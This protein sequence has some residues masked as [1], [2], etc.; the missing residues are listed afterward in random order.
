MFAQLRHKSLS[1]SPGA[2]RPATR[3]RGAALVE[4]AI[5]LPVLIILVLGVIDLGRV[6]Y[7]YEALVN[8][9]R[10]GARYCAL[11]PGDTPG[12]TDRVRREINYNLGGTWLVAVNVG[13]TTCPSPGPGKPL[14]VTATATFDPLTPLIETIT[15]GSTL[16]ISSTATMV[17]WQ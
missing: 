3:E 16:T 17:Q 8:A 2:A 11:H 6:F 13:A 15:G 14:S 7:S 10:E 1:Q 4:L 12:T 5:I 9:T